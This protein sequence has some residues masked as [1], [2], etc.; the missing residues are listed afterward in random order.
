MKVGKKYV[1]ISY[2][3]R[4]Q[5]IADVVRRLLTDSNINNW[6]APYDIPA[7]SKYA[8]EINDA[9]EG[10]ECVVL[11][12]T[13]EAQASEF[14]EK[15]IDR[16]TTYKKPIIP[17]KIGDVVLNSGF[18]YYLG[19]SQVIA[20]TE[21]NK[22]SKE[23][24]KAKEAIINLMTRNGECKDQTYEVK[25][26]GLGD[27]IR[28]KLESNGNLHISGS[29]DLNGAAIYGQTLDK[30]VVDS[31][32]KDIQGKVIR[33]FIEEGIESIGEYSFYNFSELQE[34]Y[35]SHT[36]KMIGTG[37][38]KNCQKL[39]H[40]EFP[41]TLRVIDNYAFENCKNLN[42]VS[43]HNV[44]FVGAYAFARCP[45]KCIKLAF[46]RVWLN[47]A[48]E[49]K[50]TIQ[51]KAFALS[52]I[53][54]IYLKFPEIFMTTA[55]TYDMGEGAFDECKNLTEIFFEEAIPYI[56]E[57]TF[58]DELEADVY[59]KKKVYDNKVLCKSLSRRIKKGKIMILE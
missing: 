31:H 48:I 20:L 12:L 10:C 38:F 41:V 30:V 34:V 18:R 32:L 56:S 59:V 37:A 6:M 53:K 17:L 51:A 21:I 58:P 22:C 16:S 55:L 24:I 49:G 47:H 1:F 26:G 45:V 25:K 46:Q 23:W 2:S 14:V 57:N 40:V 15:E 39:H 35:I 36:I 44:D 9:I 28:W 43:L 27:T 42:Y 33:L 50:Q 8:Y 7:G 54:E 4:N 5:Q 13:E 29:G 19:N 3:S 11:L 52:G